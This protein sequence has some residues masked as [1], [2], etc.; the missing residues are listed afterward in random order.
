MSLKFR[1]FDY[2]ILNT[3][4]L[5]QAEKDEL[6]KSILD[7]INL[8]CSYVNEEKQITIDY[9]KHNNI[10]LTKK[11]YSL[12]LKRYIEGTVLLEENKTSNKIPVKN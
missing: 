9:L 8:Y 4:R 1:L 10:P 6:E 3:T 7:K 11:L 12:A 2:I 5:T